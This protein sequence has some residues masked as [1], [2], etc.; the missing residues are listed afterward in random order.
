[1][2]AAIDALRKR[3]DQL[4]AEHMAA[5]DALRELEKDSSVRSTDHVWLD[6]LNRC[7]LINDRRKE[8]ALAI[9][10]VYEAEEER[11]EINAGIKVTLGQLNGTDAAAVSLMTGLS[12][13]E[14]DDLG[15]VYKAEEES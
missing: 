6:A 10:A 4:A 11:G 1:M 9:D 2:S 8:I 14:L 7:D 15:G 3:Q 12:G 13:E 5:I